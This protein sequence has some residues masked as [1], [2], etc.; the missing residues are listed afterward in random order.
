MLRSEISRNLPG[1]AR[2]TIAHLIFDWVGLE[3]TASVAHEPW[4]VNCSERDLELIIEVL[5]AC[6]AVDFL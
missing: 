4:Y 5:C 6:Q 1:L 3:T 2:Q